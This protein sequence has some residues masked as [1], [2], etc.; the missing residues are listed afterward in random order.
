MI[1]LENVQIDVDDLLVDPNNPR[2]FDLDDWGEPFPVEMYSE[3][4]VQDEALTKLKR[5][6]LGR[7]EDLKKSIY[8]NGYVP[9]ELIVVKPYEFADDKYIVIE[10]NRRLAA[11]KDILSET[12][13][14]EHDQELHDSL[15]M[16]PVLVY[17]PVGDPE[18]DK[19]NELILQG[20]RHVAGPREWGAYQKANLIVTLHD[21]LSL[22]F[23]V[24]DDRIGLGPRITPRYYRAY[25]ALQ[26]MK[27]NE[28]FGRLAGP[29]LFTLFEEAIRK[30]GIREW[31]D[32]S[33]DRHIFE[34]ARQLE[35]FYNLIVGD[36]EDD[37]DPRITNPRQM[38]LLGD[39]LSAEKQILVRRFIDGQIDI[40]KA[41]SDAFPQDEISLIEILKACQEA[42]Q[43]ITTD[44]TREL[45]S[46]EIELFED[47]V[48]LIEKRK[49]EHDA[50]ASISDEQE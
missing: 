3:Q 46:T 26:Q 29:H 21:E 25:K 14:D 11:I 4:S 48:R 31:L 17:N 33:S 35:N 42:L 15:S 12:P 19:K 22:D 9:A 50:L 44:Q 13:L 34:N 40:E 23:D 49:R 43:E 37:Q 38:R 24:I 10:G 16:L 45:D 41:Y 47:I 30:P 32:W 8:K 20:I 1:V 39:L 6:K 18:I 27:A 36:P 7:I 28:E 5:R 2:F